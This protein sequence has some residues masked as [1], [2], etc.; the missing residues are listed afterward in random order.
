MLLC[1]SKGVVM[2]NRGV[3]F[4]FVLLT[5]A[6]WAASAISPMDSHE[7]R[8]FLENFLIFSQPAVDPKG[9]KPSIVAVP[10][11]SFDGGACGSESD[12]F[13]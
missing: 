8:V 5:H 10:H 7:T 2:L 6:A 3:A 9:A 13:L 4:L 1:C 11:L 12:G